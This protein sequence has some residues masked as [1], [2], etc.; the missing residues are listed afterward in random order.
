[1]AG[2]EGTSMAANPL[3]PDN[4]SPRH[5]LMYNPMPTPPE[6]THSKNNEAHHVR[7]RC[8]ACRQIS[9]ADQV[10]R[11]ESPRV[12]CEIATADR[13]LAEVVHL[14]ET[15]LRTKKDRCDEIKASMILK[16]QELLDFVKDD[17]GGVVGQ[18]AFQQQLAQ[19]LMQMC[20]EASY[21][22]SGN[23]THGTPS[24]AQALL[25]SMSTQHSFL[26]CDS[27]QPLI[28]GQEQWDSPP[29]TEMQEPDQRGEQVWQTQGAPALDSAGGARVSADSR[30]WQA[31]ADAV[32]KLCLLKG[33]A[34][35]DKALELARLAKRF[36]EA[37][38]DSEYYE[39]RARDRRRRLDDATLSAAEA[40][41]GLELIGS[42][43]GCLAYRC[44]NCDQE[45]EVP[46]AISEKMSLIANVHNKLRLYRDRHALAENSFGFYHKF[47][48]FPTIVLSA[49]ITLASTVWP[50]DEGV[51]S[52]ALVAF[53]SAGN[54][55][56]LSLSSMFGYQGRQEAHGQA[57]K[58]YDTLL[59]S[60]EFRVEHY[61]DFARTG[62]NL[63]ANS[64]FEQID[65]EV[66]NFVT[67]CEKRIAEIDANMPVV[68]LWIKKEAY[69]LHK[70]EGKG[71]QAESAKEELRRAEANSNARARC[72]CLVMQACGGF[73]VFSVVAHGIL[74]FFGGSSRTPLHALKLA[75]EFVAKQLPHLMKRSSW[76][77]VILMA[78]LALACICMP[79]WLCLRC[80][81]FGAS[82]RTGDHEYYSIP[83]LQS[84]EAHWM[85]HTSHRGHTDERNVVVGRARGR[86]GVFA[87]TLASDPP[88]AQVD[89]S[90]G[91]AAV[92]ADTGAPPGVSDVAA[93]KNGPPEAVAVPR[94]K[95]SF[96]LVG[97]PAA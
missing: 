51:S 45:F 3:E 91:S 19:L 85:T 63:R 2:L 56:L 13:E 97:S 89:G 26:R 38:E 48:T 67:D 46:S 44:L 34:V 64:T 68:P 93:G 95:R 10:K 22:F 80:S 55:I 11:S 4:S 41:G 94:R 83:M 28:S 14:F 54:T 23:G 20:T 25:S 69:L 50:D 58:M 8:P 6:E 17:I 16:S 81:P 9:T 30:A 62:M 90:P 24:G 36:Q 40:T 12:G 82:A 88:E 21:R 1:M 75:G 87:M 96:R 29:V 72:A 65:T 79:L 35:A 7:F 76:W 71:M 18:E 52:S 47:L 70:S 57:A 77:E 74:T 78:I 43:P 59:T 53:V 32:T 60:L 37:L 49:S 66:S 92:S 61:L 86:S 39:G 31:V 5:P 33:P 84:P 15:V 42:A 27:A 73:I